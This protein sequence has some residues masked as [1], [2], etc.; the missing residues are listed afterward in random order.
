MAEKKNILVV[1]DSALMRSVLCD[2]I[3]S[4]ERFHVADRAI[5]GADALELLTR[6]QYDAVV[7][8][9]N[10]PKM[11]GVELLRQ[12]HTRKIAVRI[13]MASTDTRDGAQITLDCLELGA[14]DFIHKPDKASDARDADFRGQF[15]ETLYA[16]SQSAL[17]SFAKS[18]SIKGLSET[19]KVVELVGKHGAKVSGRQIVAIASSTGGPKALQSVIPHLPAN[20][21]APV[22]LVQH[23]PAGFTKS[24]AERLDNMSEIHVK[25]AEEGD[26]VEAGTVYIARGGVHMNIVEQGGMCRVHY[27]SE[28]PR[29]GVRPCANYMYESLSECSYERITCVVMTG[30]GADGTKGIVALQAA[31]KV[32]VIAQ[33]ESTCA[34]YGMP[35]SIVNTGLTDQIVPL[36]DIAR[37]IIM[38]VGVK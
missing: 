15:L 22:V 5:N 36:E 10:M 14:L 18:L 8:D 2:I 32:H 33:E 38:N 27:T 20:L 4:D 6:K 9:V 3:N 21:R 16:V 24:L 37:E 1:D 29:E 31:K 17:P 35:K 11:T 19:K 28:P 13:M 26:P 12:L 25:E 34:V 7:L 23:M 30:M